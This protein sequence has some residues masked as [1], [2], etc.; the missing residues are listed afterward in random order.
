[1]LK[2]TWGDMEN[3]EKLKIAFWVERIVHGIV[4]LPTGI[5]YVY[6]FHD[7]ILY[8]VVDQGFPRGGGVNCKGGVPTYYFAQFSSKIA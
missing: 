3:L 8:S 7:L 5:T 4:F 1:M 6:V 2:Q